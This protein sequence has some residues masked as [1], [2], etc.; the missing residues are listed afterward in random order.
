MRTLMILLVLLLAAPTVARAERTNV[1]GHV[2]HTRRAP[3]VAHRM[4]PPF[5]GKHVYNSGRSR[6]G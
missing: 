1:S 5:Y 3:V 2:V 4:F 6:R